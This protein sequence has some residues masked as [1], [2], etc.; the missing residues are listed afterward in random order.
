MKASLLKSQFEALE[1]PS[2]ATVVN[3]E[4]SPNEIGSTIWR[5]LKL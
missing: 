2:R 5:E 1:E 3:I 4:A